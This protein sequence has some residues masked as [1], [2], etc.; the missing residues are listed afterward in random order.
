MNSETEAAGLPCP[1][2][3]ASLVRISHRS[4]LVLLRFSKSLCSSS[5]LTLKE[6]KSSILNLNILLELLLA[7]RTWG[8]TVQEASA[9]FLGGRWDAVF[10]LN[11]FQS[12]SVHPQKDLQNV[13]K[14]QV[15]ECR[16]SSVP[17]DLCASPL[18]G[19]TPFVL[20][21]SD[22][23]MVAYWRLI[24]I[25]SRPH[26]KIGDF[27]QGESC[28]GRKGEPS[29]LFCIPLIFRKVF[30]CLNDPGWTRAP[31][32]TAGEQQPQSQDQVFF[33]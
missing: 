24:K 33:H 29:P 11:C 4:L 3:A 20:C 5:V 22:P 27:W 6:R 16:S 32:S 25:I 12:W 30:S 15:Q 31:G 10:P 26:P 19:F 17:L 23:T 9:S 8:S 18:I 1:D 2:S 28:C 14:S 21:F 7:R 13:L